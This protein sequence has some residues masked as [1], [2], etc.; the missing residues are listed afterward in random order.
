LE[1]LTMLQSEIK[2]RAGFTL[3]EMII[4]IVVMGV[5]FALGGMVLG[6]AFESYK[7]TRDATDVG[8]QGR[9]ALERIA[10]EL[11][12]IRSATV[13][14]LDVSPGFQI[15]FINAN[16]NGVCF[17]L[18]PPTPATPG[19]LMRSDAAS[20]AACSAV[21]SN[22]QPLADNLITGGLGFGYFDNAGAITATVSSVYYVAVT[23][24][25]QEGDI[26]ESY[27]VTVQP[28]RF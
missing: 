18:D 3:V 16:G 8:W 25:V 11:R 5:I 12:D 7:L 26:S 27:R 4:V 15:W 2:P 9:I 23:I 10:R 24:S 19:R 14:D 17:Y 1:L 13:A 20:A 6:R 22:P 28:R 21:A